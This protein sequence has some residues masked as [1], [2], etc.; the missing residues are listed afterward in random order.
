MLLGIPSDISHNP[1]PASASSYFG[2]YLQD[3]WKLTRNFTVNLGLR[4]EFDVPRTERFNR[5][6][7]TRSP[8]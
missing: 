7:T 5:L 2:G 4:Y 8:T 3:D 1:D 6:A